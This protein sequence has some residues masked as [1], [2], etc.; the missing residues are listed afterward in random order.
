[1]SVV[2][3]VVCVAVTGLALEN[4]PPPTTFE[5]FHGQLVH[6]TP[7]DTTRYDTP[8]VKAEDRGRRLVRT[9]RI[10]PPEGDLRITARVRLR[11]G[12][13]D[14]KSMH[15]SWDRAGN[16]RLRRE[17]MPDVEIVKFVTSYG[18]ET[19]WEADVSHLTPLLRGDCT[20][21]AFV[22]TWVTPAWRVDLSLA[23]EAVDEPTFWD[24]PTENPVWVRGLLYEESMTEESVRNHPA[25]MTVDIPEGTR[26]V[27]LRYY[28]TGHCTDGSGSDEFVPKDNVIVVDGREVQRFR[29]WR[30]D[31]RRYR[32][33]NPY[34][35]RWGDGSW[36]SDFSR[37]GWCP[38]DAVSPLVLDL[39]GILTPGRHEIRFG[40]ENIR[41]KDEDGHYGYWRVS[42]QL[43]GWGE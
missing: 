37:S 38:G 42:S 34:C 14:A 7:D 11:P 43:A 23:F 22:D 12:V 6:F 28:A 40:V 17:G 4:P 30:D 3:M 27:E 36:S 33:I 41:P 21:V 24:E 19:S 9:M 13:K 18:G 1:M 20:F 15:D 26:R 2:G 16:V 31:C 25:R 10:D 5:V 39:S 35:R 32:D 8:D 29:P